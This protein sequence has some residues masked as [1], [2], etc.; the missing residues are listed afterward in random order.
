MSTIG[1]Y[2]PLL[3]EG[4][5]GVLHRLPDSPLN[6]PEWFGG[7]SSNCLDEEKPVPKTRTKVYQK[8]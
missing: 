2:V 3:W 4:L 1:I 6:A 8:R 7:F 5:H